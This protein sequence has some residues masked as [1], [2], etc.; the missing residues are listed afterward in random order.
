VTLRLG[1]EKLF[2]IVLGISAM[3]VLAL[4]AVWVLPAH[5]RCVAAEEAWRE[6]QRELENVRRLSAR[7]PSS[8]AVKERIRYR[9][10]LAAQA[11]RAR[12]FFRDRTVM[13][14]APITAEREPTPAQFKDAYA[15]AVINQLGRLDRYRA[16]MSVELGRE[17]LPR[18]PWLDGPG[19]PDPEEFDDVL[20]TYWAYVLMYR[21][22]LETDVK[23]VRKL[24]IGAPV[25]LTEELDGMP[26]QADLVMYPESLGTFLR[27]M[28][29]VSR[30]AAGM[31][32]VYLT[33]VQI[34]PDDKPTQRG[35]D[36]L[37][38]V[39]VEGHILLLRETGTSP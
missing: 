18:P 24:K 12:S 19:L 22:F 6:Q 28:L 2:W 33:R 31:P 25:Y 21:G 38:A 1:R 14:T 23:V 9:E 30:S 26:F 39:H 15:Q 36:P 29:A 3:A 5:S 8:V 16:R 7:I 32:V 20:R 27:T 13:L 17:A 10:W 35:A 4:L 11:E 34:A 37:C